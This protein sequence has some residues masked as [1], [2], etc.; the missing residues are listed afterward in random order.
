MPSTVGVERLPLGTEEAIAAPMAA[1]IFRS[2]D[3]LVA[4]VFQFYGTIGR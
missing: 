3:R 2:N 4:K 1:K